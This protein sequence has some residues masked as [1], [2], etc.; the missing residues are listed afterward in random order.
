[1]ASRFPVLAQS[2]EEV[3]AAYQAHG[4]AL[5]RASDLDIVQ[6]VQ[7]AVTEALAVGRAGFD[8]G[9]LIAELGDW[10]RFYAETVYRNNVGH[11][12]SAG[13]D[14]QMQDPDVRAV[15]PALMYATTGD[16]DVRPTHRLMHGTIAPPEHPIWNQRT[17]PCGHNCFLPTTVV[18]G[19]FQIGL[20]SRYAGPAVKI[21]TRAGRTLAV[22]VN[23]PVLTPSGWKRASDLHEGDDLVCYGAT[24]ET[25]DGGNAAMPADVAAAGRAVDHKQMPARAE[26][27][28]KALAAQGVGPIVASVCTLDLHGDARFVHGDVH[29]VAADGMLPEWRQ[30][31]SGKQ[32]HEVGLVSTTES[33]HPPG[34][35]D[36]VSRQ[37]AGA[38]L[39]AA[40]CS[41]STTA[42]GLDDL[43]VVRTL[44]KQR[45]LHALRLGCA[46][47]S[48]VCTSEAKGNG[49]TADAD[50]FRELLHAH[51]GEVA[52]DKVVH[53]DVLF[54]DG[55]VYDF[56]TE[57]GWIVAGGIVTSNCRC[58]RDFLS[59]QD[60]RDRGLL[61]P[62]GDVRPFIPH[63]NV[64]PDPGF[65]GRPAA[66]IYAR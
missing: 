58:G 21:K 36:G 38:P 57:T 7:A 22:T 35:G 33:A 2:R 49:V 34:H 37:R 12:Y 30:P 16:V 26:D 44:A 5:A 11:A 14:Q 51:P 9:N 43:G 6:K 50:L 23:H 32:E 56:Q 66:R 60:L 54:H 41:P 13:I 18:G 28:F 48:H 8:A 47:E 17:P 61:A 52:T 42:L 29:V 4:F 59:R 39:G 55:H 19:A 1:M 65:G 62:N 64:G 3:I 53:V 25:L 24:V 20:E 40:D 63:P 31:A 46:A 15:I 45:P 27:A 10:P